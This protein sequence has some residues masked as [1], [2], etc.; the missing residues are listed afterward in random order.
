MARRTGIIRIQEAPE[1]S[2]GP[3]IGA[4]VDRLGQDGCNIPET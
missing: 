3:Q 4:A 1:V 2:G